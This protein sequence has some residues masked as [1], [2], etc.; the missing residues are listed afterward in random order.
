MQ[1]GTLKV[2]W[3][4]NTPLKKTSLTPYVLKYTFP[5]FFGHECVASHVKSDPTPPPTGTKNHRLPRNTPHGMLGIGKYGQGNMQSR[6]HTGQYRNL[7]SSFRYKIIA[8]HNLVPTRVLEN[9][10]IE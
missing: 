4:M 9:E 10:F 8:K 1:C 3:K 7:S 2:R 6:Y 5:K